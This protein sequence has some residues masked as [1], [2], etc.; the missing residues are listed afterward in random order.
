[1]VPAGIAG[2]GA[3]VSKTFGLSDADA[4]DVVR[5]VQDALTYKPV[6]EGGRLGTEYGVPGALGKIGEGFNR[7]GEKTAEATG[8][9][10]VGALVNAGPQAALAALG[11]RAGG[12]LKVPPRNVGFLESKARTGVAGAIEKHVDPR[13]PGGK[14][15]AAARIFRDV[16]GDRAPSVIRELESPPPNPLGIPE[17]AGRVAV[18]TGSAE[19]SALQKFL[20]RRKPSEFA[21]T[22]LDAQIARRAGIRQI[23]KTPKDLQDAIALRAA[24][25]KKAYEEAG[26]EVVK[27]DA[28]IFPILRRPS[29]IKAFERARELAKE[30]GREFRVGSDKSGAGYRVESLHYVKL[31]LDDMISNPERFGMGAAETRA[32]ASTRSEFVGW[33]GKKSPKYDAAREA[34]AKE[35]LPINQMEIGQALESKL[36]APLSG[37]RAASF[38]AAVKEPPALIKK[39]TGQARYKQLSEVMTP[40]QMQVID[41]LMANLRGEARYEHLANQGMES[42]QARLTKTIPYI[43]PVGM[44]SPVISTGRGWINRLSAASTEKVLDILSDIT[45]NPT[46]E[47][48]A[49]LTRKATPQERAA[50]R[51]VM[52]LR[53]KAFVG[54]AVAGG[55]QENP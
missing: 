44:F 46:P 26:K 31:A 54:A 5:S 51:N 27:P 42:A 33:L 18:G 14:E 23:G 22:E 52:V 12:A 13:L 8:S 9:P 2:I 34:Y 11:G 15:R 43:P 32:I 20:S 50:V 16:V 36:E 40:Q 38:A 4:A 35:S 29:M 41:A 10:L 3:M 53:N 7:L 39:S 19:F 17:T 55:L 28:E 24:N 25:A 48:I 49:I 1:M 21:E 30:D 6:T 37:E 45:R 47:N